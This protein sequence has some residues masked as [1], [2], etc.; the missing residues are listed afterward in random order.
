M[1]FH[2]S[3]LA[4]SSPCDFKHFLE[5]PLAKSFLYL[6]S[7]CLVWRSFSKWTLEL[8]ISVSQWTSTFE[9]H[10]RVA[11]EWNNKTLSHSFRIEVACMTEE[12]EQRD[13][14]CN[15]NIVGCDDLVKSWMANNWSRI[16]LLHRDLYNR[17][18]NVWTDVSTRIE[19]THGWYDTFQ[20]SVDYSNV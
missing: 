4:N 17:V 18:V 9:T 19:N 7:F 20:D 1:L 13:L 12:V 2:P 11:L 10:V 3:P 8:S 15:W 5:T 16:L 14:Y 6:G